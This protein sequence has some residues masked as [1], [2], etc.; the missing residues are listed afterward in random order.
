MWED[1]GQ[2]L[3][4]RRRGASREVSLQRTTSAQGR[5]E[6]VGERTRFEESQVACPGSNDEDEDWPARASQRCPCSGRRGR[7]TWL[8][9]RERTEA[10]RRVV[11]KVEEQES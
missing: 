8:S 5:K 1:V 9:A 4:V 10:S 6:H 11:V 7:R 2:R 3:G